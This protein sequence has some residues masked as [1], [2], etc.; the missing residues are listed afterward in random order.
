MKL[1]INL[2]QKNNAK[3]LQEVQHVTPEFPRASNPQKQ[4]QTH[5]MVTKKEQNEQTVRNCALL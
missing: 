1:Q 3:W 2:P 5:L 4:L